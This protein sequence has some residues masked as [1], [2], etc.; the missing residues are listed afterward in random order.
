MTTCIHSAKDLITSH[1]QTRAGF[2]EAAMAKN[3][4]AKPY[5]EQAKTLKSIASTVKS[6]EKLIEKTEIYSALLTAAGLSDKACNYFTDED[7]KMAIQELIDKFLAPAGDGFVDELVYRF[8]LIKGDTLGGSMRNYV[9][10]IAQMKLVRK[11]LCI[12]SMQKIEHKILMRKETQWK[13]V[14]YEEAFEIADEIK[15]ITWMI[16][17]KSKV[18]FFNTTIPLVRNNVDISLYKGNEETYNNG[19]IVKHNNLALMFGELKGG[20]DPAGADEHW[21]TGNTALERI[22]NA[23]SDYKIKT[24]FIAASIETKMATE[25]YAQLKNK[26]LAKAANITVDGQLT[27][28][29]QW[30]ISL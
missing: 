8:L 18:L 30:L 7:K 25:I 12:F 21:K 28:Y 16:N 14:S 27:E 10:A 23:F 22:R 17:K 26:T 9:G 13:I 19:E 15:A 1:E 11:I 3:I 4:K 5:I 20:I 24:S 2:I 29:C 6:P